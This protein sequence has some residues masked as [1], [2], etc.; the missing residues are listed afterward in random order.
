MRRPR[1]DG[2]AAVSAPLAVGHVFQPVEVKVTQEMIRRFAEASHDF[3]PLHLDERWMGE[4][5]FGST[6]YGQ[7]IAHGLFTY[8]LVTRMLT[9]AVYAMGGWH[10]R[11]EMRFVAPVFPGDTVTTSGRVTRA[12]EL[13]ADLLYAADVEARKQDGTVVARGD[14]MGRV[15]LDA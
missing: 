7:V 2:A 15:P 9:D 13:G 3:N 11:C 4:A 8:S 14:A 6:R 1:L 10:E 5:E 12:R